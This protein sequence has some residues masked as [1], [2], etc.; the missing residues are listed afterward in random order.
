M[1]G[2][3]AV[4]VT[5]RGLMEVRE[6]EVRPPAPDEIL[7]RIRMATI[8]GSDLHMWRNE[9]PWF[10]KHPGI[11]GHEM[12]G[13]IAQLGANRKTDSMGHPLEVGDRVAYAYFVPCMECVGCLSGTT[14][15]TNRYAARAPY[16]AE[17]RPFLGAFADYCYLLPGQW[18]FKIPP[19]LPDRIVAPV[20]C[21]LAQIVYGLHRIRVWL[22]DTVVVQGC[23]ALGLY[24]V[25]VARDMGAA[26]VIAVDAVPERLQL[27]R[28][29]GADEVINVRE[30]AEVHDRVELVRGLTEGHMADLC[31]EVAGV[32]TVIQEG[33]EFLRVGGRYLWMGNIVPGAKAEIVPHDAVRR[34]KEILG[35]L[36]Y[37]RWAIPRAL[38]WLERTVRRYPFDQLVSETFPLERVNEAFARAEWL[39][40]KGAVGRVGVLAT[41]GESASATRV[42]KGA[43]VT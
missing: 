21:A 22:G 40:G 12:V 33:L 1:K 39:A 42:P 3:A 14:G 23:G 29:F 19:S 4:T 17:E 10:Q 30:T 28:A 6:Y 13:A 41:G 26:R 25:A 8:C 9:V 16:T 37:E 2:R 32:P 27:A 31:V 18:V 36:T 15:C 24:T 7:V 35:V 38:A 20:N 43:Q 34:P 11:Q 5:D